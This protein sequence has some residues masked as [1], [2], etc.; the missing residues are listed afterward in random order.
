MLKILLKKQLLEVFRS[1]FYNAKKNRMRSK[2][3]IAAWFLF[4]IVIMV[5]VLGGMFT[6]LSLTLCGALA[7]VGMGWLYFALMGGIAILLGA[8]GS[9]FNTYAGLYLSRDND[10]LLSMPIPVRAIIAARLANV[11][12]MGAMYAAT[13]IVPAIVVYCAVMGATAARVICGLLL[14]III[15]AVVLM[16]STLLGWVVAK[17]SLKLK[18][19]SF[20]AVLASL[21]FMGG[22]Y[23]FYF[24][25]N[26][27]IQDLIRNAAVYGARIKGAARAIYLFGRIGT[28]DWAAAAR[29]T[30]I[31]AALL[32]GVWIVLSRSFLAIATSSGRTA[33][34]RYREK[35]VR[36]KTPFRA[37]LDKE[38]AR[39]AAS[40]N[41]MLNC[42]LGVLIIPA[43]GV[44]LLL[45]GR[46]LLDAA[47]RAMPTRP[48]CVEVLVCAVLCLA[49]TMI[50]TAAPSVSLEGRSLWIPQSLPVAPRAVLRAKA[51][52]QWIL[53]VIPMLFAV[54]C[55]AAALR[56]PAAVSLAL[57]LTPLLFTAFFALFCACLAIKLPILRWTNEIAPIK[58][59][60]SVG[61]ALF[62]GW[63]FGIAMGGLYL[64]VGYRLGP[65]AYLLIWSAL[66]A[67]GALALLRWLDTRGSRA[68]AALA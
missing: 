47:G 53:S 20:I 48:G 26:S 40:P 23:F 42:S 34:V 37:L 59:S 66:F 3:S 50:D 41:Y 30:A 32:I 58:Q 7:K 16:L 9:V 6:A 68:F 54:A 8:F 43:C 22:Y 39:F 64:W 52:T 67:A 29:F 55:A 38:F 61:I 24:K 51:L 17:I 57:C 2:W 5:G 56:A 45:K 21:L 11:W 13:A 14:F 1:Y 60:A 36:Q 12:L 63:A 62:G 65:A 27:L 25:A 46:M 19:K 18:N 4:F 28:G 31:S 44:L 49:A 15:T 33:R 10:L 35:A